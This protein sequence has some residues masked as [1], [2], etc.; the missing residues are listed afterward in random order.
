MRPLNG[1][2]LT[3][4]SERDMEQLGRILSRRRWPGNVR[5]L[6][7]EVKC[8]WAASKGDLKK[9]LKLTLECES[10]SEPE[11]LLEV[12]QLT[13]WNRREAARLLGVSEGTIRAHIKKLNLTKT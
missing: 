8:I 3:D 6:Q 2:D 7:A 11:Q 9:M 1:F 5:Q 4:G 12:L 13:N 10:K